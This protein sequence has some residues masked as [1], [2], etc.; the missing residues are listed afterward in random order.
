MQS[1]HGQYDYAVIDTPSAL[2]IL[3]VNA[4][5]AS[6]GVIIPMTA[7]KDSIDGVQQL[8][9]IITTVKNY[10]NKELEI[11][12]IVITKYD[13]RTTLAK[14]MDEIKKQSKE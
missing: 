10:C 8:I 6:D 7:D 3:T 14:D 9:T 13:S 12:G 1:L 2:S 5:T 11:L 4:L